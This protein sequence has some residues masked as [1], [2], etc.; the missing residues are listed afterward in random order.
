MVSKIVL[1]IYIISLIYLYIGNIME[2][3]NKLKVIV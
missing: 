1:I 2:N 3:K